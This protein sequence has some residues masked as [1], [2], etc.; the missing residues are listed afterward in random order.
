MVVYNHPPVAYKIN[1]ANYL[2]IVAVAAVVI[3]VTVKW[4]P[5]NEV[6]QINRRTTDALHI[7]RLNFI[8]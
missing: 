7:K 6:L 1:V 3:G 8:C 2:S 4:P 5:A